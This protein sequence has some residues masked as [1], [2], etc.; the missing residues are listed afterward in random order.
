MDSRLRGNDSNTGIA[1]TRA[2][3][4]SQNG[5]LQELISMG[6]F[7]RPIFEHKILCRTTKV[8]SIFVAVL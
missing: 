1:R 7:S 4:A 5:L 2:P 6:I 3:F 8:R